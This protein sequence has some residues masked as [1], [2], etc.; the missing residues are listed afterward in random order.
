MPPSPVKLVYA[1]STTSSPSDA[2]I[3]VAFG[4]D[5]SLTV[6]ANTAPTCRH[7]HG[8]VVSQHTLAF[9]YAIAYVL[10]LFRANRNL[11]EEVQRGSQSYTFDAQIRRTLTT[12]DLTIRHVQL[13]PT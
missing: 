2:N 8:V 4:A 10:P 9:A 3:T 1:C 6:N 7:T 11:C 5:T 13:P 12:H